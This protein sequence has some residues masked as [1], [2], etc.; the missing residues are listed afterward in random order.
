M[1]DTRL[2]DWM[3]TASGRAFWP[4]DPRPEDVFIEDIAHALA[5]QC[6]FG[7]HCKRPY[8][9]AQ[10]SV[11]IARSL[12]RHLALQG[13]LHDATEAFVMDLIRPIKSSVPAYKGIEH[14]VHLAIAQ[15]FGLPAV[16]DPAIKRADMAIL[17][18]EMAQLMA[19]PP[20]PWHLPEPP[21]GITI[22]PWSAQRA[23]RIFLYEFHR[24]TETLPTTRWA[25]LRQRWY[26]AFHR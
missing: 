11:L 1:D 2:G 9:I 22:R 13:L 25:R 14:G 10:H 20:T 18:D 6:R 17:A 4:L 26:Q 21:L 23:R 19:P 5:F 3:Q 15:R 24:L 16:F 8:S 7:G 12:P